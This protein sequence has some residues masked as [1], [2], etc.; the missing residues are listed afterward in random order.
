MSTLVHHL[1]NCACGD[2]HKKRDVDGTQ[3]AYERDLRAQVNR[4]LQKRM[5]DKEVEIDEERG[6]GGEGTTSAAPL[7]YKCNN[8]RAWRGECLDC[9]ME[10]HSSPWM[11]ADGRWRFPN[12]HIIRQGYYMEEEHYARAHRLDRERRA[13]DTTDTIPHGKRKNPNSSNT[14]SH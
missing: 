12:T 9:Y 5:G 10:N 7:C 8:A 13:I 6:C 11:D 1:P 2:C 3:V 14:S 4:V